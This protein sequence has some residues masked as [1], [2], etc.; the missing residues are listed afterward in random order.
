MF[1]RLD[2]T[3]A[4]YLRK[5]SDALGLTVSEFLRLAVLSALGVCV[6]CDPK[7]MKDAVKHDEEE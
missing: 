7:G 1:F 2:S 3:V 6:P 5:R 4:A